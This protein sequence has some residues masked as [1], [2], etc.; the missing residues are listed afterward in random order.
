MEDFFYANVTGNDN[1][2]GEI[3]GWQSTQLSKEP[4]SFTRLP[5]LSLRFE[6]CGYL[7]PG[8]QTLYL[9]LISVVLGEFILISYGIYLGLRNRPY[10]MK[11]LN[12]LGGIGVQ[13]LHTIEQL[14]GPFQ[15]KP[16]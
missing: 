7:N 11:R 15:I 5:A 14:A 1:K 8:T 6:V 2:G 12:V 4:Y 13:S 9:L 16:A 3:K 10:N